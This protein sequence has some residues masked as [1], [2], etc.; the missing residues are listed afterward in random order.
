VNRTKATRRAPC[1]A[2]VYPARLRSPEVDTLS[3]RAG[4]YRTCQHSLLR[5]CD[6]TSCLHRTQPAARQCRERARETEVGTTRVNLEQG[7]QGRELERGARAV[8]TGGARGRCARAA[9]ADGARTTRCRH[10]AQHAGAKC[11]GRAAERVPAPIPRMHL[12]PCS[13]SAV[14]VFLPGPLHFH[15]LISFHHPSKADAVVSKFQGR[16]IQWAREASRAWAREG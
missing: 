12:L 8:R 15:E 13:S 11:S 16:R 3:D 10:H 1:R 9:R 6:Q 4:A 7:I 2:A 14:F 5:P